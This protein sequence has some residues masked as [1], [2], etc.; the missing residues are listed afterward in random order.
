MDHAGITASEGARKDMKQD[1]L[2]GEASKWSGSL[3]SGFVCN[4]KKKKKKKEQKMQLRTRHMHSQTMPNVQLILWMI[5]HEAVLESLCKRIKANLL[6]LLLHFQCCS[7][8][9]NEVKCLHHFD[10]N[11]ELSW[12]QSK[13][14]Q[15]TGLRGVNWLAS[16]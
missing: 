6:P 3:I 12:R 10:Q 14:Y 1:L 9:L 13:R 4:W 7:Q 16:I 2:T 5:R 8:C 15:F 11:S